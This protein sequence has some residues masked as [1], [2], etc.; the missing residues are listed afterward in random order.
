[1]IGRL[2][3]WI[4]A[5]RLGPDMPLTYFLSF[6]SKLSYF[7][8]KKK[9]GFFGVRS[10]FRQGAYAIETHKIYIGNDVTIRP[11]TML[12][13]SPLGGDDFQIVIEEKAL[14]GSNVHIYV[15]NHRFTDTTM[16]IYEQGHEPVSPVVIESGA[17]IGASVTILPGVRIGKNSVVGAGSVVTKDVDDYSVYAGNPARKIKSLC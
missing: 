3:Y 12:F 9:F 16:P 13:A 10:Q 15:S 4:M 7:L 17:W 2:K 11:N 8:S 5:K 1:M 6:S 14:I